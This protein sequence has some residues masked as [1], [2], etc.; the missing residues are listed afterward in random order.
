M[1]RKIIKFVDTEIV[2]Y[3]FHQYNSPISINSRNI[4]KILVSN[5]VTFGKKVFSIEFRKNVQ[6]NSLKFFVGCPR[7]LHEIKNVKFFFI[8][9][10]FSKISLL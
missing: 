10:E 9:D 1:Q 5:K 2:K 3:K 8:M 6:K 4:N 7:L